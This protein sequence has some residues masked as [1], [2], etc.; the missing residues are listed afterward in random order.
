[1][2]TPKT[3]FACQSCGAQS[4]KWLGRC[5]D[6]GKWNTFVEER[7]GVGAPAEAAGARLGG[8][9]G[10]FRVVASDGSQGAE[11]ETVPF[12]MTPKPPESVSEV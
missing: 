5:A 1:M 4:P 12:T 9:A 10:F 8:G 2:K 7:A 6:C 11:A 3:F